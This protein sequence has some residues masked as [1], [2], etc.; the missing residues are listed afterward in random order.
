MEHWLARGSFLVN[1]LGSRSSMEE[2]GNSH[3]PNMTVHWLEKKLAQVITNGIL[4]EHPS[5]IDDAECFTL[6]DRIS[7]VCAACYN[8]CAQIHIDGFFK[9][10]RMRRPRSYHHPKLRFFAKLEKEMVDAF[11]QVDLDNKEEEINECSDLSGNL[12]DFRAGNGRQQRPHVSYSQTGIL[13][14]VCPH[15]VPIAIL[16]METKGEKFFIVHAMLHFIEEASYPGEVDFYSYDVA[17]RLKSYLQSQDPEL[18]QQVEPKLVLG[19]LHAKS[20]KCRQWNVGFTK[21]GSGYNDGEQGE[22]L[23]SWMLKYVAFL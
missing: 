6:G 19:Y 16:P 13:T 20:H 1:L 7:S 18:H 17:C 8:K 22:C 2:S 21:L 4:L 3:T 11:H 14:G 15:R 12:T 9:M 23:N 10:R 5:W